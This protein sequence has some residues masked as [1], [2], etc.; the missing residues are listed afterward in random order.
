MCVLRAE[1][2]PAIAFFIDKKDYRC[3]LLT[4]TVVVDLKIV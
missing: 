3:N 4:I 1:D 2:T